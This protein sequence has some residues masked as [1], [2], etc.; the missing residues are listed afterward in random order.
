M[1]LPHTCNIYV[2]I[3]AGAVRSVMIRWKL[4]ALLEAYNLT[5]YRL[6]KATHGKLSLNA[7]YNAVADDLTAIKFESLGTLINAL[8]ELTGKQIGV[9]NLIEYV[10]V[11]EDGA[12]DLPGDAN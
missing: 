3:K 8:R 5:P 2:W 4:K 6:A 1:L 10:E 12:S 9:E 7:V 11:G